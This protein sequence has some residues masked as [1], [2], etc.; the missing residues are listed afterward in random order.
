M[1]AGRLLPSR[2]LKP[3]PNSFFQNL[4]GL[5][6]AALLDLNKSP[7]NNVDDDNDKI[8]KARDDNNDTKGIGVETGGSGDKDKTKEKADKEVGD[9]TA[10]NKDK[11]RD[12][13][14]NDK[15]IGLETR[16]SADKNKP[17]DNANEVVEDKTGDQNSLLLINAN[18]NDSNDDNN[19]KDN[20]KDNIGGMGGHRTDGI[21]RVRGVPTKSSKRN[22]NSVRKH[23]INAWGNRVPCAAKRMR[24]VSGYHTT[25]REEDLQQALMILLVEKKKGKEELISR[26]DIKLENQTPEHTL[27]EI[28][29]VEDMTDDIPEKLPAEKLQWTGRK[30]LDYTDVGSDDDSNGKKASDNENESKNEAVEERKNKPIEPEEEEEKNKAIEPKDTVQNKTTWKDYLPSLS[31]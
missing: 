7:D 13:D 22:V 5:Y 26:K 14:N 4:L 31:S 1:D 2:I 18:R 30:K 11:D 25:R 16:G 10:G 21:K 28:V 3:P 29:N 20:D 24:F 23:A 6:S 15:G 9:K 27:Q 8:D 17:K 19:D 12:K